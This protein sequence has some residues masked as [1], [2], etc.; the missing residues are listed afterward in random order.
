MPRPTL[1]AL[2][3]ILP[4]SLQFMRLLWAVAHG[5]DRTSK[6]MA[7][8]I[9]VTGPQR[10]VLKVVSLMPGLS[11]GDLA[12][13]LHVHPSTLTG[14]LQ[15]LVDQRLLLRTSDA[16]D[17]RRAVLRLTARGARINSAATA[18]VESAI[19]R[20]L[21]R[22]TNGDRAACR[23]VLERIA[24]ELERETSAGAQP[25]APRRRAGR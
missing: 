8:R 21:A 24:V 10:L 14:V 15:R 17:R 23:A 18:T 9:G 7:R 12:A 3:E 4:D 6:M 16:A 2:E 25:K 19:S 13:L 22:T 1:A 11:A 5:L 20:V